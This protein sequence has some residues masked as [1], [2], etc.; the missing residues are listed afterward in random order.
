LRC[1]GVSD[2]PNRRLEQERERERE[3]ELELE[4]DQEQEQALERELELE[5]EQEQEQE[6]GL[7]LEQEQE[8]VR[9]IHKSHQGADQMANF[10]Q[11][12]YFLKADANP[13]KTIDKAEMKFSAHEA[14]DE[15]DAIKVLAERLAPNHQDYYYTTPMIINVYKIVNI[16]DTPELVQL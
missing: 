2:D 12:I 7:E 6:L 15:R 5:Q 3:R 11:V 9:W 1:V 8:L 10:Y 16:G 13:D 4:L 14:V